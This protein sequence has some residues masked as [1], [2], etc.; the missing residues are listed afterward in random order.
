[1]DN[2][3]RFIAEI[4][5]NI[6]N[7]ERNVKKAQAMATALPNEIE[8]EVD[9]DISKFRRGLLQAEALAR[10]FSA[11][12]IVKNVVLRVDNARYRLRKFVDEVD[13]MNDNFQNELMRLAKMISAVGTV[14]GNVFKGGLLSSFSALIPIVAGL[15]SAIMALGNALGVTVGNILGFVGALGVAGLGAAAYG[16]LVASVLSRYNDEAF[17]AT[18]SSSAFTRALDSIKSAWSGIVDQ[19]IDRI[20]M[21]M[22]QAI[23]GAQFALEG[24]T[25]FINDVV[26]SMTGMT[27]KF[28]EFMKESPT[29]LRFYDNMSTKGSTVFDSVINGLGQFGKGL[30]DMVNAGMPLIENVAGAFEDMGTKF[31]DWSARMAENDGFKAFTDYVN[32]NMPKIS[33]IFGDAFHGIIDLFAAFGENSSLVLDGLVDMMERFREWSA[34][35]KESDGF[36]KFIDYIQTNGPTVVGLIGNIVMMVVNFAVAMAPIAQVVLE[37]VNAIIAWTAELFKTNPIVAQVIGVITTLAGIL[38]A[39]APAV[40]LVTHVLVPLIKLFSRIFISSGLVKGAIA[41]LGSAFTLLSGP[42]GIVIGA[43]GMLVIALVAAYNEIEWFR[44]IV[45]TA[46]AFISTFIQE[47]VALIIE[48]F[49]SFREQGQGIFEALWNTIVTIISEGLTQTYNS[50]I[51]WVASV[52]AAIVAWGI[53][54]Y[55]TVTSALTQFALTIA[56]KLI[57]AKNN[58]VTWIAS[59]IASIVA[60]GA[61][62]ISSII[63]TMASFVS[64]II[65]GTAS[66]LSAIVSFIASGISSI[67]SFGASIVSTIIS[68]MASFVSSI[69][70]GTVS[71][72]SAISSFVS[73]AISSI[74]SFVSNLISNI[75]SGMSS[76]VSSIASGTSSA[77]STFAS[78]ISS[79]ISSIVSFVSQIVSNITSGMAQFVSAI[80]SGGASAVSAVV[81]MGSQ[82]V[83]S[84]TGF[85]GDM[86][87]AGADLIRGLINGIKNMA[88]AAVDAAKSVVGDAI[89]GAKNLLGINSPSRVFRSFGEYTMQ[90]L[91]IGINRMASRAVGA[92]TDVAKDM[93]NSFAP[94]LTTTTDID[95]QIGSIDRNIRHSVQD[96]ID[97]GIEI[98]QNANINLNLGN[99]SYRA[100]AEDINH[101]NTRVTN[102][103]ES[104]LGGAY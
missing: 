101:E 6:R 17:E 69:I 102:L 57:E 79:A 8:T 84:V 22:G 24:L 74:V 98:N 30:V 61:S 48:T 80:V 18:E 59:T 72:L 4:Q 95:S 11:R 19:N 70:S 53:Q 54:L 71:A 68:A 64:S 47:R 96:D 77:L 46:W 85:V 26:Q 49:N 34:T 39:L 88:G 87:S 83:S 10:R 50:I 12:N 42:V 21:Q 60:F 76:F 9:A 82:I 43:I 14:L 15:T 13:R 104:Y 38:M 41:L 99:R 29:M 81:S 94:D 56:M 5:A 44:N 32:E 35:I 25:P 58:F 40:L 16:G 20:F 51:E 52:I 100:F 75:T 92:V 65:S 86:V 78:F 63:S 33:S 1:M 89:A 27:N 7:F 45:N 97:R 66:A 36:Q 2:I 31:A 67:V 91:E 55:S 37:V 23:Y 28:K 90:G 73:S 3:S 93:T 62:I 103:E